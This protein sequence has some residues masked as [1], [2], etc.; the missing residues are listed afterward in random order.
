MKDS[1][2]GVDDLTSSTSCRTQELIDTTYVNGM[3]PNSRSSGGGS[4][5]AIERK[6]SRAVKPRSAPASSA[7]AV[8]NDGGVGGVSLYP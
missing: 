8:A 1:A 6:K 3:A 5:S 2:P 4:M 7:R